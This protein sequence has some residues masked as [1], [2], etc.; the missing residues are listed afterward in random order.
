MGNR[1]ELHFNRLVWGFRQVLTKR[2]R[3][4]YVPIAFKNTD[5]RISFQVDDS[6]WVQGSPVIVND[7]AVHMRE[8]PEAVQPPGVATALQILLQGR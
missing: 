6:G 4:T 8:C 1:N 2:L 5:L 3:L 7:T